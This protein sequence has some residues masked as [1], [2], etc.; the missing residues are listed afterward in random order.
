[1]FAGFN[2]QHD[3]RDDHEQGV[4][5]DNEVVGQVRRG[6][7]DGYGK[8]DEAE[9]VFDAVHPVACFGQ[10]V[11]AECADED[12]R[13]AGAECQDIQRQSAQNGIA[14]LSDIAQGESERRGDAGADDQRGEYAHDEDGED[15]AA[16][17]F[18]ALVLEIG[19]DGVGQLDVE[20]SEH[21]KREDDH[22]ACGGKDDPCLLQPYGQKRAR[23]ACD[24][25]D[26][27]VGQCQTLHIRYGQREGAAFAGGFIADDDAGNNRQKRIHTGG[28][29]Q[30]YPCGKKRQQVGV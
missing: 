10:D 21:G 23:Q 13:N 19:L 29:A 6:E 16:G 12:Q 11:A 18:A 30:E 14:G 17:E 15:F 8:Q 9:G 20:E 26:Q 25:A 1:M 4:K 27:R 3:G 22:Q 28:K 7:I 5:R 24:D 2:Q